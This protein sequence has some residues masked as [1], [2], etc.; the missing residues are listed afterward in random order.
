MAD[1]NTE[2]HHLIGPDGK[3]IECR[4]PWRYDVATGAITATCPHHTFVIREPK[5]FAGVVPWAQEAE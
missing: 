5:G 1:Y 2:V 4:A 3:V